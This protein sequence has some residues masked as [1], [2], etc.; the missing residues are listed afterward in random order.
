MKAR[1]LL[2]SSEKPKV[3]PSLG[4][5]SAPT[6][7]EGKV[8]FGDRYFFVTLDWRHRL[9]TPKANIARWNDVQGGL[10]CLFLV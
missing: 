9:Q 2:K 8:H 5:L 1:V 4:G 6:M 3:L 10:Y 7:R